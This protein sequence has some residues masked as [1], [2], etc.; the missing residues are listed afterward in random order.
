MSDD[1]HPFLEQHVLMVDERPVA[2]ILAEPEAKAVVIDKTPKRPARNAPAKT[3]T[4]PENYTD[5][6]LLQIETEAYALDEA[7]Y[8]KG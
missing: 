1:L 4:R 7:L 2:E 3:D 5:E 6:Q 8:P